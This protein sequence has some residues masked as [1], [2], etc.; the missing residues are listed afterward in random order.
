MP[1][2]FLMVPGDPETVTGGYA[3]DRA[4][5]A[6][7]CRRGWS[8]RIIPLPA[9]FPDPANDSIDST[10]DSIV[11]APPEGLILVDGLA[12][13]ALP[14][15]RLRAL[16]RPVT[17]LVH[18]PLALEGGRSAEQAAAVAAT[19]RA[20]LATAAAVVATSPATARALAADY[21]VPAHRLTVA[22]PGTDP[23]PPAVG[24]G[25]V[26]TI[27]TV[28]T[29]T[30]RKGHG[31]LVAALDRIRDHSWRAVFVGDDGRDPACAAA[32]RREIAER[33]LTERIAL[34]GAVT[35]LA[36]L[37]HYLDAD[38]F[39]LVSTHEGYGMAFAEALSAGLPIIAGD[40]GAVRDTVPADAGLL[41][42]PG[43]VEATAAALARLLDDPALR[44]RTAAAAR[45]AGAA[46]PTWDDTA[47]AVEAALAPLLA[48]AS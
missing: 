27:L 17:A 23:L 24:T 31:T 11:G 3:Y 2:L 19:E 1:E 33:G 30:P 5:V 36:L 48:K 46:L 4:L 45:R 41:V 39:A 16:R 28:A 10:L 47:A 25:A 44:K 7:L 37:D 13:G 26:P 40:G 29:I 35:P 38:L 9:D 15:D 32:L 12:F 22:L 20:A 43:D 14:A 6:S 42:P 34:T 21:G 18:H 8:A